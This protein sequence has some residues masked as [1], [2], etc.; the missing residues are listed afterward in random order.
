MTVAPPTRWYDQ[1][2]PT[3][4]VVPCGDQE[5][6]VTWRRGKLV[7]EDHSLTAENALLALGGQPAPCMMVLKMWRDQWVMPPE[8]LKEMGK[9]LGPNA[10][11][12]PSE[13]DRPRM[14]AKVRHWERAWR[15]STY[16]TKH[17]NLLEEDL[18][19][20]A[21]EPLQ[22]LAV[23]GAQQTG[24]GVAPVVAIRL[25][26]RGQPI[27]VAAGVDTGRLV[28]VARLGVEWIVTVWGREAAIVD[29]AFVVEVIEEESPGA[30]VVRAAAW[31][32]ESP[33][34]GCRL[35]VGTAQATRG[36][37][38]RWSLASTR[39]DAS[40]VTSTAVTQ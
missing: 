10:F 23:A 20:L 34:E 33:G 17:G 4:A 11:L 16:I 14:V 36:S 35:V 18:G 38:G 2:P 37:D 29:D 7:L 22:R 5:H 27:S 30:M 12:A 15:H 39:T 3:T 21:I 19:R 28:V 25:V 8:M 26:K 1:V 32:E 40:A 6:R 13:L 24:Q 9:W 31:R